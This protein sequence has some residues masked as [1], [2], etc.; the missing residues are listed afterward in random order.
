M[1]RIWILTELYFPERTSTAYFLTEIAQSLVVDHT[2]GVITGAS[3]YETQTVSLPQ[4]E[5]INQVSIRRCCS[6][7][8]N[9][10]HLLGR[11]LNGVTRSIAILLYALCV[12]R[13]TDIVLVVTNPPL[14][15]LMAVLL[16]FLK[17]TEFVL[18]VH[19]VYP[20]VL[21]ATGL[22]SSKSLIY[23]MLQ[24]INSWVYQQTRHVI[25]LGRDMDQ[26]VLAKLRSNQLA[27][28]P[29][30]ITCIPNWAET[31]II[32]PTD[33]SQ[34]QLLARLNL[35]DKFVI[36]YAGNMG[37][38]HDLQIL[39]E[40]AQQVLATQPNIYFLCIGAGASKRAIERRIQAEKLT[41][42]MVLPYFPHSEK[43]QVL[44][45]C[46]IGIIS[47]L[48]N[49]AG[50]SVPSRMYNQMAA[51]K[52]LIAIA[53]DWSE[54]AQVVQENSIGWVI[55]PANVDQLVQILYVASQQPNLLLEMGA[56]AA[57]AVRQKY[58]L[59]HAASAYHDLF[60]GL[61]G[62]QGIT[63]TSLHQI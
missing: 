18:L 34:N 45:A 25:T 6:T 59:F 32:S 43:N 41:N 35:T 2:V 20:E 58:T 51:G 40:A 55:E 28:N 63:S 33:R 30:P 54:L 60:S 29:V 15:P 44:N 31:D 38:T 26:L 50:V 3:M 11:L 7:R 16:K 53:D 62:S 22:L 9:K 49:M 14:L 8:F 37:R 12:C 21:V 39:L 4:S 17:G 13:S 61:S 19:D 52:P 10:N 46:D 57:E 23:R 42:V 27:H 24:F 47:F 56:R 1:Q 5:T 48:P 36:L